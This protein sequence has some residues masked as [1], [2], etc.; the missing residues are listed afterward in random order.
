[1]RAPRVKAEIKPYDQSYDFL[2]I[3]VPSTFQQGVIPDGE[4]PPW[5]LLRVVCCSRE[6]YGCSSGLLDAHR[7][8]LDLATIKETL[9]KVRPQLVG[10]N[11]TSVNVREGQDLAKICDSL[12][13]P[14]A[15]GGIHSTLSP[16]EAR[17]DFPT[18][19]AI[20]RGNGEA[21]IPLLLKRL[22]GERIQIPGVAFR[23][24]PIKDLGYAA[25]IEPGEQPIINQLR[26][27]VN[28]VNRYF[29]DVH[30]K[31][32]ELSESTMFVTY[33]CPFEC[34][35]CSSPVMVNRGVARPYSR[36]GID[37]IVAEIGLA[38]EVLGCNAVHF[39]DDMAFISAQN[40]VDLHSGLTSKGLI[41]EFVWRGLTRAQVLLKDNFDDRVMGLMR[42]TG[43][44]KIALGV[45][46]GCDDLLRS[47]K[48]GVTTDQ[49][50]T[51]V[52]KLHRFGIKVKAFFIL[53][54]PDETEEQIRK[55]FNFIFE[56]QEAGL[57]EISAFQFKPYPGTELYENL[58][59]QKPYLRDSLA[60]LRLKDQSLQGRSRYKAEAKDMWLPDDLRIAKVPSGRVK[61]YVIEAL[62]RFYGGS[63]PQETNAGSCIY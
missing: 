25:R 3:N 51:A 34:T 2:A 6:L 32:L 11:P 48:K 61:E 28:P 9:R 10:L 19:F 37:K 16:E 55:T 33:G 21:I 24:D 17:E 5:G 49:I 26:Y 42:E 27:V 47:I 53:G 39:L 12:S 1:V 18:A 35:F 4:E 41:G 8:K 54:F 52:A 56:L 58:L 22:K 63:A 59:R 38:C 40:I 46:S 62:N 20:V 23:D 36:P 57:T 44:W 60:Y 50:R 13:I 14:F 31:H 45:E 29:A 30:G 15:L 7:Q 43:A